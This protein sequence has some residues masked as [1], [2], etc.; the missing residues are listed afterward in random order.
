MKFFPGVIMGLV[1]IASVACSSMGG[2]YLAD[3]QVAVSVGQKV[4]DDPKKLKKLQEEQT[5]ET[6]HRYITH[7]FNKLNVR[8]SLKFEVA[9]TTYRIGW[10]RDHMG[11]HVIVKENDEILQEF[12]EVETTSRSSVTEKLSKGLA[13]RMYDRIKGL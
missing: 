4:S 6:L 13:R 1:L 5:V 11:V 8:K 7:R 2:V 9:I 10:G 3:E 12:D